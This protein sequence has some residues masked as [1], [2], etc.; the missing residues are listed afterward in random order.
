MIPEAGQSGYIAVQ[1]E[2]ETGEAPG[3]TYG[4][5]WRTGRI[6][7]YVDGLDALK[8]AVDKALRTLRYEHLV[9]S[10]NYGTEWNL[11][12]GQDRLL[13]GPEIRRVVTEALLQD[14]RIE[15]VDQPEV[16]FNGE[17]VSIDIKVRSRYGDIRIRKELNANG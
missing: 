9:Y 17:N 8:Q 1:T 12:L 6:N 14:D 5:D 16:S 13:A 3:L 7:G 2:G 10:S 15:G 4:I 11:V